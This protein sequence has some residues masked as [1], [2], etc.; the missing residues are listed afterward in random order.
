MAPGRYT[1]LF[2]LDEAVALAAGHRPCFECRRERARSFAAAWCPSNPL[3]AGEIDWALH[4]ELIDHG[5]R[6]QCRHAGRFEDLP[7]GAFVFRENA[8]W[9]VRSNGILHY[10]PSGYDMVAPRPDGPSIVLT[11]LSILRALEAGYAPH[12]HPSAADPT[13][14]S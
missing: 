3:K 4:G 12:L 10:T 5:T 6:R 8:P 7:D 1:E 13:A 2:F 11:P 14:R 9:L